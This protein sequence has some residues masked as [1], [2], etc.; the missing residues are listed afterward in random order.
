MSIFQ[1]FGEK[2]L[3]RAKPGLEFIAP[4][5]QST[6]KEGERG[7]GLFRAKSGLT[8]F[9]EKPD[10]EM[11]RED[12]ECLPDDWEV[13]FDPDVR[14]EY[15]YNKRTGE[16]TWE[17]PVPMQP[18]VQMKKSRTPSEVSQKSRDSSK[19]N[20]SYKEEA[21]NA[22]PPE[23]RGRIPTEGTCFYLNFLHVAAAVCIAN[24]VVSG[25]PEQ[26]CVWSCAVEARI[27]E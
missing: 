13:L 2:F 27:A 6:F 15:Y 7:K 18:L 4:P 26:I 11:M 19:R 3:G 22:P 9:R 10:I 25:A 12:D 23:D 21:R 1:S 24:Y 20:F 14:H 17:R 16:S 5:Q 8:L